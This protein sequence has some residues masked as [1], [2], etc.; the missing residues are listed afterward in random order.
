MAERGGKRTGA[1]RPKGIQAGTK[2]ER[3]AA[4]QAE[5]DKNYKEAITKADNLFKEK[6]FENARN[7]YRTAQT[8]KPEEN[9]P[10]QK[11]EE[12]NKRLKEI[13]KS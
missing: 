8:V 1:G 9:Y 7:E 10:Q 13:T 5:K 2:A 4:I 6:D 11:I 12:K 3:L